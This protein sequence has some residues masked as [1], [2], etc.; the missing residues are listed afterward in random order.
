MKE[1]TFMFTYTVRKRHAP[2]GMPLSFSRYAIG[3]TQ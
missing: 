2:R 1:K 3:E